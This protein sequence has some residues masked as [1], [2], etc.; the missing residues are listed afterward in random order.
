MYTD[1][2]NLAINAVVLSGKNLLKTNKNKINSSIGKDIKLQADIET[3]EIIFNVLKKTNINI[4]SEES[5][6][7]ENNTNSDLCWIIDP[8]DGSLN[9]SRLIPLSCV[10]IALWKKDKPILGVI[11]DYH[12][13][14]IFN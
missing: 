13:N 10:S 2:L 12:H 9:Y 14:N 7:I 4:L 1:L 11:Y 3:E 6:F 5:G 8:L